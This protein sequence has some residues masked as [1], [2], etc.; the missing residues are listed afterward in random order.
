MA[1]P[2][3][4][5]R[6]RL[7]PLLQL[8]RAPLGPSPGTCSE[9]CPPSRAKGTSTPSPVRSLKIAH[10][11]PPP[12]R[13]IHARAVLGEGSRR[14]R[15][16]ADRAPEL[17]LPYWEYWRRGGRAGKESDGDGWEEGRTDLLESW[18]DPWPSP[19]SSTLSPPPY[20]HTHT[21][22]RVLTLTQT[23]LSQVHPATLWWP[24]AP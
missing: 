18:R 2:G 9:A 23:R 3:G 12:P 1:R 8:P 13:H 20:T 10:P 21:D 19:H 16:C 15:L 7:Q 17:S 22:T 14:V 5:D 4:G 24:S 11:P 6:P